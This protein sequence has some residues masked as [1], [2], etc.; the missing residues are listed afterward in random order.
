MQETGRKLL[1]G[2]IIWRVNCFHSD[3]DLQSTALCASLLRKFGVLQL[4]PLASH[5]TVLIHTYLLL[6][7][8]S[9]PFS[10]HFRFHFNAQFILKFRKH[11]SPLCFLDIFM[12]SYNPVFFHP[13]KNFLC[14]RSFILHITCH[15]LYLISH[16]HRTCIGYC[17]WFVISKSRGMFSTQRPSTH[18][19]DFPRLL[20]EN[21]ETGT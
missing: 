20:H 14:S 2:F 4:R 9:H 17:S 12:Y 13:Y 10:A 8:L 18:T 7:S 19:H 5:T 16:S 15:T 21:T 1:L 3:D 6:Q 11:F